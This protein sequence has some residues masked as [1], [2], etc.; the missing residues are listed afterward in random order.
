[1]LGSVAGLKRAGGHGNRSGNPEGKLAEAG[2]QWGLS[3]EDDFDFGLEGWVRSVRS[4]QGG[5][6]SAGGESWATPGRQVQGLLRASPASTGGRCIATFWALEGTR[7]HGGDAGHWARASMLYHLMWF[8]SHWNPETPMYHLLFTNLD[9]EGKGNKYV[10]QHT[11]T[12]GSKGV[13]CLCKSAPFPQR[14]WGYLA[15][16][17][18]SSWA[19]VS[20]GLG[21][22]LLPCIRAP[23]CYTLLT[24]S[25]RTSHLAENF[26]RSRPHFTK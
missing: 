20:V 12:R 16:S 17:G 18:A 7:A 19:H 2:E 3:W 15:S 24:A 13:S 23:L 1:M 21:L 6:P 22:G 25:C 11:V 9:V 4:G 10:Q 8:N 14:C 5:Q 26:H